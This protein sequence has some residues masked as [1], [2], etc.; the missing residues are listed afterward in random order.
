MWKYTVSCVYK[1]F[2]R[3]KRILVLA[4][5]IVVVAAPLLILNETATALQITNR[6]VLLSSAQAA[7]TTNFTFTFTPAQTT[8]I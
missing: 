4:T 3:V 6:S 8:M 7:G 2:Y 5:A 1:V